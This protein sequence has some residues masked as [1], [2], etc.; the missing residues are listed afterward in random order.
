MKKGFN[1]LKE[2]ERDYIT[3]VVQD[4]NVR[5]KCAFGRLGMWDVYLYQQA[6]GYIW[7]AQCTNDS[8]R[9]QRLSQ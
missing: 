4:V 8:L 5:A 1:E 9:L 7:R 3:D 6:H 2:F